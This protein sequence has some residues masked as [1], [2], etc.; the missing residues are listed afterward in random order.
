MGIYEN[1]EIK[2]DIY[3]IMSFGWTNMT[4]KGFNWG[5]MELT[6]LKFIR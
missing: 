1:F 2:M 4:L 3:G 5:Y 6:H